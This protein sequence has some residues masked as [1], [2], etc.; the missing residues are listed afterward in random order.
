MCEKQVSDRVWHH[1]M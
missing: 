1:I